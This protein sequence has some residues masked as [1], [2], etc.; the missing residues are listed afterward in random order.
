[1]TNA[2]KQTFPA[3]LT[4]RVALSLLVCISA[5]CMLFKI[6]ASQTLPSKPVLNQPYT[7]REDF[8]GDSLGQFASYPPAQDVGYEP[9]LA[10]TAKFDA[11]GGRSLMRVL[12][13]NLP[14]PLRFGFIR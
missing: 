10:P 8:H 2:F 11:P 3:R 7:L 4:K 13:P 1:M 9:S 14:G 5:T 12:K 6:G